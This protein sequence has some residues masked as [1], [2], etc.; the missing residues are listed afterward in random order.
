MQ[1]RLLAVGLAV[2][3]A[4][5]L[6]AF[7]GCSTS[8]EVVVDPNYNEEVI[9]TSGTGEVATGSVTERAE[10]IIRDFYADMGMDEDQIEMAMDMVLSLG[11][12]EML[13]TLPES[14]V[15]A[16]LEA[17]LEEMSAMF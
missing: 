1:K 6:V 5:S 9:E 12:L 17:M 10:E 13:E 16:A 14:E 4:F 8:E 3:M 7:V 11:I 15:E 2:V